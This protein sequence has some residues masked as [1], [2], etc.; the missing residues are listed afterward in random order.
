MSF[1]T[2]FWGVRGSIAT[3]GDEFVKVG[4]NTSCIEMTCGD[5]RLIFDAGTGI[6]PCGE[7]LEKLGITEADLFLS[8]THWDH[9]NGFPFFGPGLVAGNKFHIR[10]G[11]LM[12]EFRIEDVL[13]GQ[14]T[15]PFYP[16]PIDIMA[17]DFVFEDFKAGQD[18]DLGDGIIVKTAPLNHPDR[19]TGYRVEYE[20]RSVCYI[21]DTEHVV[22]RQD[23]VII[24][25]VKD[26]DL[27][28]Y[29]CTYADDNFEPKIGWGHSTWE[30]GIR[31]SQAA[32]VKQLAIFHHDPSSKDDYLED[33]E[34]RA[35]EIWSGS[36]L[37]REGMTISF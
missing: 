25:L 31:V 8:H 21:T 14:M 5:R 15:H 23:Q 36:F 1:D 28:I 16:V 26:A 13:S 37:A 35:K 24:D 7:N 32:G 33:L 11:H 3:P 34:Q 6:R 9:I 10:A 20:G 18:F 30:E 12:P 29:D 27:M 22:G 2:H 4:G 19:A 17:A